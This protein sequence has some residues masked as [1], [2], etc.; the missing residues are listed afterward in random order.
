MKR[1]GKHIVATIFAVS[2]TILVIVMEFSLRLAEP[3]SPVA[4]S[5]IQTLIKNHPF[6]FGALWIVI[7][8]AAVS[9]AYVKYLE[10]KTTAKLAA[11]LIWLA[12]FLTGLTYG[13][14]RVF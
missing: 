8:G 5:Y 4:F 14:Y 1:S 2:L 9:I 3:F 6:I 12:I 7:L 11:L 10:K 13:L